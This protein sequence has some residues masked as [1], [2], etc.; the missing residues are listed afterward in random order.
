M[1]MLNSYFV[2]VSSRV[3]FCV[4]KFYYLQKVESYVMLT[5][6]FYVCVCI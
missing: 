4:S 5:V 3:H 1:K 2:Y 6:H